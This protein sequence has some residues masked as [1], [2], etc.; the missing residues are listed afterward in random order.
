MST[1]DVIVVTQKW[2]GKASPLNTSY[3]R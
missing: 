3:E 1:V 2:I